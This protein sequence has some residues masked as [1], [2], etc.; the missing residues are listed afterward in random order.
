MSLGLSNDSHYVKGRTVP[1]SAVQSIGRCFKMIEAEIAH[2]FERVESLCGELARNE[3]CDPLTM[4]ILGIACL[5]IAGGVWVA[6]CTAS[7]Y[8]TGL[9]L[10]AGACIAAKW[11]W[12]ANSKENER[13]SLDVRD[14]PV[15]NPLGSDNNS[16]S[17]KIVKGST[18]MTRFCDGSSVYE[19]NYALQASVRAGE[20]KVGG[21]KGE[22]R[23]TYLPDGRKI[24]EFP[25]GVTTLSRR[26]S[27]ASYMMKWQGHSEFDSIELRADDGTYVELFANGHKV[28]DCADGSCFEDLP[29]G[30]RRIFD[31][32]YGLLRVD[33]L[34]PH[35]IERNVQLF[36][37][38]NV[39]LTG[40]D[41]GDS[42]PPA[43]SSS[44]A[45][46]QERAS[47]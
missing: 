1:D 28:V 18:T 46:G 34:P 39:V 24:R 45:P 30:Q 42:L 13:L 37:L 11:I 22:V 3:N 8:L 10:G 31:S 6:I 23:T 44:S 41:V 14:L 5:T 27:D 26:F 12:Q 16:V 7:G 35:E 17:C 2:V 29:Q 4:A 33:D 40:G 38:M 25:D 9:T 20:Q 15:G 43:L 21:A 32:S 47:V 36:H 19:H